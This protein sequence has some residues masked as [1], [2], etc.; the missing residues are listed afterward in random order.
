[1][2]LS[3]RSEAAL[4]APPSNMSGRSRSPT[5]P[6]NS[7][8]RQEQPEKYYERQEQPENHYDRREQPENS[9]ARREQPE[10]RRLAE[11]GPSNSTAAFDFDA[12]TMPREVDPASLRSQ[13]AETSERRKDNRPAP[14]RRRAPMPAQQR[15]FASRLGGGL[16]GSQEDLPVVSVTPSGSSESLYRERQRPTEQEK[17]RSQ[18][19]SQDA[20]NVV[21]QRKAAAQRIADAPVKP[22]T[23]AQESAQFFH[24][25]DNYRDLLVHTLIK[26][27]DVHPKPTKEDFL[28]EDGMQ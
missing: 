24:I 22:S 28:T 1:M 16:D 8:A 4:A 27:N 25:R 23:A 5:V 20:L 18:Q 17:N 6:D 3:S 19:F 11:V 26:M 21:D 15:P 2:L 7:H 14:P 10:R 12:P 13:F 9:Y